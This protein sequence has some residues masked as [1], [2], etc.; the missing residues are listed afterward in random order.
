MVPPDL[1]VHSNLGS[2][3]VDP[4]ALFTFYSGFWRGLLVQ[5][6]GSNRRLRS[7]KQTFPGRGSELNQS[8][9]AWR[10]LWYST[11]TPD[12]IA[13]DQGE[14][15]VQGHAPQLPKW[16]CRSP[17]GGLHVNGDLLEV[18]V[19]VL[20]PPSVHD[21]VSWTYD[22]VVSLVADSWLQEISDL[23]DHS[24]IGLGKIFINGERLQGW[25]TI[26]EHRAPALLATEGRTSHCPFCGRSY[27]VLHGREYFSDPD[28]IGRPFI[29]NSNGC[30]VREDIAIDRK[31]R[32]PRGVFEPGLVA[33]EP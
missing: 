21:E 28:V 27:T 20:E 25:S 32:T 30:F 16:I 2:G 1:E 26:N 17:T 29:I 24:K 33:F 12:G 31:L 6:R 19:D 11:S 15:L 22:Y 13:L 18:D 5:S 7:R 10:W 8:L 4:R 23:I 9:T 14:D 3:S